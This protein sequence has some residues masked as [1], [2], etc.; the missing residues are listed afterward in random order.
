MATAITISG[1]TALKSGTLTLG[2]TDDGND[3]RIKIFKGTKK[4]HTNLSG[5]ELWDS[6][7]N[8]GL[9]AQITVP[10]QKFDEAVMSQFLSGTGGTEG[11]NG[12]LGANIAASAISIVPS[13]GSGYYFPYA[14]VVDSYEIAKFGYEP[15]IL[16][17][18]FEACADPSA[19]ATAPLYTRT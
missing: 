15:K 9:R 19:G 1:V 16:T 3:I 5:P 4:I 8:L 11:T 17:V 13:N 7:I 6:I 14:W 18:T 10:L 2:Y 12:S